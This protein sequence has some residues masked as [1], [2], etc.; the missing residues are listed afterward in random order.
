ML[1]GPKVLRSFSTSLRACQNNLAGLF[2]KGFTAFNRHF[3][4]VDI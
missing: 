3:L 2:F 1:Q 4:T